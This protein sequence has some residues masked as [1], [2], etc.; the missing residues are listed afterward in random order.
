MPSIDDL[1]WTPASGS[2]SPEQVEKVGNAVVYL[3]ERI[4]PLYKTKL[5]K[6]L[7]LL[8]EESIKRFGVPMFGLEYLVWSKGPVAREIVDELR[9]KPHLLAEFIRIEKDRMGNRV[10]PIKPFSDDEFTPHEVE[11]LAELSDGHENSSAVEL[12]DI[13]HDKKSLWYKLAEQNGLLEAFEKGKETSNVRM[14]LGDVVAED[15]V[16]STIYKDYLEFRRVH[17]A[18]RG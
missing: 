14:D 11:L 8:D 17:K 7:Y 13:T 5:L 16:K 4:K 1:K 9:D 15:P 2:Y 12:I 18:L 10:V 6:L 3:C